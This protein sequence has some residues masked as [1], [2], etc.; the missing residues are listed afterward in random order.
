MRTVMWL[1]F[2]HLRQRPSRTALT[3]LAT[4]C[5][6]C[7]VVWVVSSYESVLRSMDHYASRALG[8]YELVIDPVSRQPNREVP[9]EALKLLRDDPSVEAAD[10]MWAENV[11]FQAR[12]GA[13]E[14]GNET[15]MAGTD[16]QQP[17]FELA[18]GEWIDND[19]TDALEV[20]VSDS[21]AQAMNI[22]LGDLLRIR[23]TGDDLTLTIV[24]VIKNPPSPLGGVPMGTQ[25]LPSPGIVGAFVSMRDA[26]TV[27]HRP[28]RITFIGVAL[29][30]NADVHA[31]RYA[32]G[33]PLNDLPQPAQV[34]TDYD[35]EEE[36]EEAAYT[37]Q[38]GL[39]M[40][41]VSAVAG[42]LAFLIV[43]ST[44]T[45]GVSERI[46]QFALLRA[47]V[48]TRGQLAAL[49][50]CEGLTLAGLGLLLGLPLGWTVVA[51]AGSVA[52]GLLRHGA[53]VGWKSIAFAT[54]IAA[55][56]AALASALPAACATRVRPLDAITP[57]NTGIVN[58]TRKR[59]AMWR[60]LAL[61]IPLIAAAPMLIFVIPVTVENSV[62]IRLLVGAALLSLGILVVTP[63]IVQWT[64][65]FVG[66]LIARLF[67]LPR[68]LLAKQ[69]A[70][71]LWRSVGCALSLSVGLGLFVGIQVW[72]HSM[73]QTFVPGSWVPD[74]TAIVGPQPMTLE[75]AQ[76]VARLPGVDPLR[77][78]PFVAEQPRLKKDLMGSAEHAS[79]TRQHAVI[80]I[81]IDPEG[82]FGGDRPLIGGEWIAGSPREAIKMIQASR[83]CVVSDH[84]LRETGLSVGDSFEAV[85]PEDPTREVE[86]TIAGALR[87][88]GWHWLT[89]MTSLRSRTHRAGALMLANYRTVRDDFDLPG[90]KHVWFC[91]EKGADAESV[92]IA[93]RE[94]YRSIIGR[95]IQE[96]GDNGSPEARVVST[97]E[98]GDSVRRAARFWLW[99]MSVMPLVAMGISTIGVLNI[100]LAAVQA[101]RWE[102]GVLRAIGFTRSTLVRL[103]IAEGVLTGVAACAIG[104]IFG[105]IAGWCGAGAASVVSWFGGL[106]PVLVVPLITIGIGCIALLVFAALAAVWP[107]LSVGRTPPLK[108][109]Q[110][111]RNQT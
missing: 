23:Q 74:A 37:S 75:Q 15:V 94:H 1:V 64:D 58:E 100:V 82:A 57:K 31:V 40:W 92:D 8:R 71:N 12:K 95:P 72:G 51:L 67:G 88:D 65:T 73:V 49:I 66:P 5:A 33:P 17:P 32:W 9:E 89:K 85:P 79:V 34:M 98:V 30:S 29:K 59:R 55:A 99:L 13:D 16:A 6:T 7:L 111:G 41:V 24:G 44:L 104:L 54:V 10:P 60:L 90:P 14:Y 107:A 108:L 106:T 36:I 80:V 53:E 101:R 76:A 26:Q 2:S 62:T 11:A 48:L 102:L 110:L 103:V 3:T 109:L 28:P 105:V 4:A 20:V 77:C 61:A 81:G 70:A 86:Y 25:L 38:V 93:L 68:E 21:F 43:F 52:D 84:F 19:A 69:L 18:R 22:D 97:Q 96:E 39:Q 63:L 27:H 83:G 46:R 87:M 56:S 45:M 50:T 91:M 35:L 42:V 47:I 78:Q